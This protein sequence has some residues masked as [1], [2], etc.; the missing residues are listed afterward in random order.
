MDISQVIFHLRDMNPAMVK[1]WNEEFA[2]YSTTVK[3]CARL[4]KKIHR[5]G[6]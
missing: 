6:K 3:V 1:A 4:W 5:K 2:P